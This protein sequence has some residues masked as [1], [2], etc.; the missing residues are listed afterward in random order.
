MLLS[1]MA[2]MKAV[3]HR[4]DGLKNIAKA[5][6]VALAKLG[7]D[8]V[9]FNVTTLSFADL[10]KTLEAKHI[11]EMHYTEDVHIIIAD[12]EETEVKGTAAVDGQVPETF[13]RTKLYLQQHIFNFIHSATEMMRYMTHKDLFLKTSMIPF[14]SCIMKLNSVESLTTCSWPEVVNTH[15]LALTSNTNGYREMMLNF[16]DDA[17]S[18]PSMYASLLVIRKYQESIRKGHGKVCIIPKSAHGMKPDSAVMP[19]ISMEIKW[20]DDSQGC[21]ARG[22]DRRVKM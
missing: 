9:T 5:K 19:H 7:I 13:A 4:T 12:L 6:R 16:L 20:I 10:V 2:A 1:D 15:P 18:L 8:T 11:D 17:C 22:T 3:H 21:A 14:G